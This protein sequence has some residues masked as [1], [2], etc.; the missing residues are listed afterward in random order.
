[1]QA[2]SVIKGGM[3]FMM[4]L[5]LS[6][7]LVAQ[8]GLID[9]EI[10]EFNPSAC[11]QM[12]G[13][14]HITPLNGNS[15]FQYSIDGG[16]SFQVDSIFSNLSIGSYIILV[17]DAQQQ[18]SSFKIATLT[19]EGAPSITGVVMSDPVECG[20]GGTLKILADEGIGL[21]QYSIDGGTTFQASSIFSDVPAG[22]YNIVVRNEDESCPTTYP[23]ISFAPQPPSN[24]L[25]IQLNTQNPSCDSTN[26]VITISVTGGSG[27][28]LYLSLIHISEP[29]RPY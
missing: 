23:T 12:D 20:I 28:Y 27:D 4:F 16:A 18:F 13:A 5:M 1:M 10:N 6:G 14:I 9:I 15:P 24:F 3:L 7:N 21:L 29:T 8:S 17:R 19:A 22:T 2:R 25:D 11:N 26:G